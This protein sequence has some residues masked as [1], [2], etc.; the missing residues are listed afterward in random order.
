MTT[1]MSDDRTRLRQSSVMLYGRFGNS[2]DIAAFAFD[3][4]IPH[5]RCGILCD[6][7]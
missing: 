2:E 4:F 3:A 1:R 7:G 6:R 5:H